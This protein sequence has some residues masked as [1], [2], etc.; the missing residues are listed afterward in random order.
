MYRL[1]NIVVTL[2]ARASRNVKL[3][4]CGANNFRVGKK[5]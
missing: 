4:A 3:K 2:H 5:R 1:M